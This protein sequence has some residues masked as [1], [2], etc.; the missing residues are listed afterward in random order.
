MT[1][2]RTTKKTTGRRKA[3]VARV[4]LRQHIPAR[5]WAAIAAAARG[6]RVVRDSRTRAA[7]RESATTAP[8]VSSTTGANP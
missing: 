2:N 3:A 1:A 4:F 7:G 6:A 8:D 5:T